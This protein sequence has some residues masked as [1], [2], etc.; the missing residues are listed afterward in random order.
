[1]AIPLRP[2]EVPK[3]L[4]CAI[5]LEFPLKPRVLTNCSHA[6]CRDCIKEHLFRSV[7]KSC[8][9][10]RCNCT[11]DDLTKLE[12]NSLLRRIWSGITVKCEHNGRGCCWTGSVEDYEEHKSRC[13]KAMLEPSEAEIKNLREVNAVLQAENEMLKIENENLKEL[14]SPP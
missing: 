10:C 2:E 7:D 8:P 3:D 11:E 13:T 5:C 12:K 9:V 14:M 1:M 4:I 6:F